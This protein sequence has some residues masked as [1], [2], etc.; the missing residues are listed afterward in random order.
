MNRENRI[1]DLM[2]F[3]N[4]SREEATKIVDKEDGKKKNLPTGRLVRSTYVGGNW[5]DVLK[6][7][8][9]PDKVIIRDILDGM[10]LPE[11]IYLNSVFVH[12]I[13]RK[14]TKLVPNNKGARF[15][16]MLDTE[17]MKPMFGFSIPLKFVL[18]EM[19]Y[20]DGQKKVGGG[21]MTEMVLSE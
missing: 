6:V 7:K 4:L 11:T 10:D 12:S 14:Y 15:K 19:G 16:R 13:I 2:K 17:N 5:Q 1:V 8:V 9:K 18:K 21:N 3:R 20:I